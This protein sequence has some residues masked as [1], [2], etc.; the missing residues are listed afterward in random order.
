MPRDSIT[1][2]GMPR[3]R[4]TSRPAAFARLLMTI[5][6]SAS[7]FRRAIALAIAS[8]LEPRPDMRMPSRILTNTGLAVLH[9]PF[10][11]ALGGDFADNPG[12]AFAGAAAQNTKRQVGLL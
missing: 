4:A 1:R 11:A 2:S 7:S 12:V 9:A 5:A 8:K 10:A 6:I 3:S